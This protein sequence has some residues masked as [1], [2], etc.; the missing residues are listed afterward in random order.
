MYTCEAKLNKQNARGAVLFFPP[1]PLYDFSPSR[2]ALSLMFRLSHNPFLPCFYVQLALFKGRRREQNSSEKSNNSEFK[3]A[4]IGLKE[5]FALG[6]LINAM[7]CNPIQ[8]LMACWATRPKLA[9]AAA[10]AARITN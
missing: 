7:Q 5:K 6:R 8:F 3:L 1:L 10:A 2:N 9:A 4:H